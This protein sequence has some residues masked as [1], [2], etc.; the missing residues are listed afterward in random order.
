MVKNEIIR[1]SVQW[2]INC[3]MRTGRLM[4][5]RTDGHDKVNSRFSKCNEGA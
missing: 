5:R 4:D 2:E 3:S 1:K